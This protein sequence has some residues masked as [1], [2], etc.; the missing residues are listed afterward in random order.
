[1]LDKYEQLALAIE[2]AVRAHKGQFDRSGKPYILHPL[3]LM[4]ELMFDVQLAIVA[5]LHD[6]VE[7][8]KDTVDEITIE[9]L[10]KNFSPRVIAAL[11]LLTHGDEPYEVYI[12]GICSNYDAIRVKRKDLEHN[13]NITRLKGIGPKDQA[14]IVKYH[15]AFV[16]LT[17]AKRSFERK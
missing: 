13:S 12:E 5:V 4:N 14:R 2:I 8:T 3:H 16:R 17:E 15:K 6:V 10:K 1:M 11:I 7:D 9:D